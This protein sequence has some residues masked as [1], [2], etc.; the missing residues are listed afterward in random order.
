M[1]RTHSRS[2][3]FLM[4]IILNLFLFSILMIVGLQFFIQTHTLTEQTARLHQAVAG[5]K[6]V[7]SVFENGNGTRSGLL[8][9]YHYGVSLD[10]KTLLFLD[11]DFQECGKKDACFYIT[12]TIKE[13]DTDGL[14]KAHISC[15]TED[16]QV[17]YSLDACHY[18]RRHVTH[19]PRQKE[20]SG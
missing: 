3:I 13:T 8:D 7:A 1:K 20:V 17:I 12:V 2:S 4:E 19:A 5:C 10:D 6:S 11:S 9:F 16:N 14:T 15:T 18:N